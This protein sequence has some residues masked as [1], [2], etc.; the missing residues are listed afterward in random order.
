MDCRNLDMPVDY[1]RLISTYNGVTTVRIRYQQL[2]INNNNEAQIFAHVQIHELSQEDYKLSLLQMTNKLASSTKT[3]WI[4]KVNI[5][6]HILSWTATIRFPNI[7]HFKALEEKQLAEAMSDD[8][9]AVT[10]ED[11]AS[12][13]NRDD[14]INVVLKLCANSNIQYTG[15]YSP[16]FDYHV[17]EDAILMQNEWEC[18]RRMNDQYVPIE[19]VEWLEKQNTKLIERFPWISILFNAPRRDLLEYGLK[20]VTKNEGAK[21]SNESRRRMLS[22]ALQ[23]R[24]H[25]TANKDIDF[26]HAFCLAMLLIGICLFNN[27]NA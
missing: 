21:G 27:Q 7:R 17:V 3:F 13:S 1:N 6:H 12:I 11:L 18:M 26:G 9:I 4:S 22:K 25:S 15:E 16:S 8:S 2:E 24:A 19:D 23:L 14:L 10:P 20:L 5:D